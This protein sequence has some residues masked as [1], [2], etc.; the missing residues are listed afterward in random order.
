MPPNGLCPCSSTY[1]ASVNP[2]VTSSM[3]NP[4]FSIEGGF[5]FTMSALVTSYSWPPFTNTRSRRSRIFVLEFCDGIARIPI[6]ERLPCSKALIDQASLP[7][8]CKRVQLDQRKRAGFAPPRASQLFRMFTDR[9]GRACCRNFTE[10][11]TFSALD[12]AWGAR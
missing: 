8:L 7:C 6:D 1:R 3:I 5:V 12:C 10:R 9:D 11:S 2:H 4:A